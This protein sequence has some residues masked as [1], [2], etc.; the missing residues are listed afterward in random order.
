MI[1]IHSDGNPTRPLGLNERISIGFSGEKLVFD[2]GATQA[3]LTCTGSDSCEVEAFGMNVRIGESRVRNGNKARLNVGDVLKVGM[4]TIQV[5]ERIVRDLEHMS[6]PGA[7]PR[8]ASPPATGAEATFSTEALE[9]PT[10]T[11]VPAPNRPESDTDPP[12]DRRDAPI[13]TVEV[14][15]P[16]EYL[17]PP[18][19]KGTFAMLERELKAS[20]EQK[21]GAIRDEVDKQLDF[22]QFTASAL[23]ITITLVLMLAYKETFN[24][25]LPATP[26]R[27][28]SSVETTRIIVSDI[29]ESEQEPFVPPALPTRAIVAQV[30]AEPEVVTAAIEPLEPPPEPIALDLDSIICDRRFCDFQTRT[31]DGIVAYR[32]QDVRDGACDTGGP[33]LVDK[34]GNPIPKTCLSEALPSC[35]KIEVLARY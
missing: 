16:H 12:T 2:A 23:I 32:A 22:R 24:E 1:V 29:R 7:E 8:E 34:S 30:E 28:V 17:A 3:I 13:K 35:P 27:E 11:L 25:R 5:Q 4:H 9:I 14:E 15:I 18:G 33:C 26:V 10:P 21:L 19:T 6:L 20:I 31:E